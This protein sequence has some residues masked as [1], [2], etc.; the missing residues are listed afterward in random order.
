MEVIWTL[1]SLI[2]IAR[3]FGFDLVD[4]I[5]ELRNLK[6]QARKEKDE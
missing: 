2:V 1:A 5:Q 4:Q 6:K 3:A